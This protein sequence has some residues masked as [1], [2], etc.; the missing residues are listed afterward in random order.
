[1]TLPK[2]TLRRFGKETKH[3]RLMF[4]N[5][6]ASLILNGCCVFLF[7]N[8]HL[9]LGQI[10][11]T[12]E[13]AKELQ[14]FAERIIRYAKLGTPSA[15]LQALSFLNHNQE[16]VDTLF[17]EYHTR[18]AHFSLSVSIVYLKFFS[19]SLNIVSEVTVQKK[20]IP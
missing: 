3:R 17:R 15:R 7:L 10:T 4:Q 14:R 8:S 2:H 18:Y 16:A 13:K 9:S 1:M 5:L 19:Q 20:Q 12:H 11:T 6:T